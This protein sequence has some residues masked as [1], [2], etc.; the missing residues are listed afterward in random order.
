MSKNFLYPP[1]LFTGIW[2]LSIIGLLLS[3]DTFY[4]VSIETLFVYFVGAIAFS[5]GGLVVF[6]GSA[7]N[8]VKPVSF[9]PRQTIKVYRFLDFFFLIVLIGF[10]F[11]GY[12]ATKDAD[13]SNPLFLAAQRQADLNHEI[14]NP[15]G[16]LL[17]IATFLAMGMHLNNDGSFSRKW[18][19]YLSILIAVVYGG[20]TGTKGN[21]VQLIISLAFISFMRAGRINFVALGSLITLALAVF[22]VGLLF[23]NFAYMDLD[24][25]S[26]D[27]IVFLVGEIQS[28]WLGG[29]VI[30]ERIVQSPESMESAQHL[31]RFFLETANS[32]GANFYVPSPNAVFTDASPTIDGINTYTIYFSYFKDYGWSGVL[33]GMS[34]LGGVLT[35]IYRLAR[36]GN[37]LAIIFY[38]VNTTGI[39]LSV[40]AEHFILA[41]NPYIKMLIFFYVMYYVAARFSILNHSTRGGQSA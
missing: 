2:L 39:L 7:I 29:L 4:P 17:V 26:M 40:Q 25:S 30:F 9:T 5:I 18:R 41:L 36:R 27:T 8:N 35:W 31:N 13:F 28:Y 23:V 10:P 24:A 3:G 38:G 1:S 15:L 6:S 37:P 32:L 21:A 11:F 16:N 14:N 33:L 12:F 22:A 20:L 19:V 34:M